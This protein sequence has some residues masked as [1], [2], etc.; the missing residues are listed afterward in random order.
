MEVTRCSSRA[1]SR[2]PRGR[3]KGS[4]VKELRSEIDIAAPPA[5]VWDILTDF[6]AYPEWNPFI[7]ELGGDLRKGG[8]LTVKIQPPGRKAM[9]FRPT[10]VALE[11]ER[12]L[13]WLGKLMVGGV[14]D[15][16][17][18]HRL[19]PIEGGTRYVQSERFSGV[20]VPFTGG[21]LSSA[22]DGFDAMCAALKLR[23]E[24]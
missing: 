5:R 20:L 13:R 15:G 21:M 16:E 1:G 19:D 12:E 4:F 10:V 11:P 23:A 17:H 3:R 9:T 7:L 6:E 2:L 18:S 22:Q 24:G 8:R 14:F